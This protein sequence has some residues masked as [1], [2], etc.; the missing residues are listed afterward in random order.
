MITTLLCEV[1]ITVVTWSETSK[2]DR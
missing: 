2:R 1:K